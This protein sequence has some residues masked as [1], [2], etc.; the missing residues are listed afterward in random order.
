MKKTIIFLFLGT[1]VSL[2]A[3]PNPNTLVATPGRTAEVEYAPHIIK[4][5]DYWY[6]LKGIWHSLNGVKDEKFVKDSGMLSVKWQFKWENNNPAR[7]LFLRDLKINNNKAFSLEFQSGEADTKVYNPNHLLDASMQSATAVSGSIAKV[8]NR[9]APVE[10][11]LSIRFKRAVPLS[12]IALAYGKGRNKGIGKVRY[13]SGEK[14]LIPV[15]SK[16]ENGVLRTTFRNTGKLSE[17]K[18]VCSSAVPQLIFEDFEAEFRDRLLKYPFVSHLMRP[19]PYGLSA[20]NIHRASANKILQKYK[21]SHMGINFAEWDSQAFFQS[22]NEGNRLF[23]E[24]IAQFGAKPDSREGFFNY[25]SRFWN[26]HKSIFFDKIWGM[27]GAFGTVHYGTEWGGKVAGLELTNH[28]STIPHRTLLRYT[29]GAGR[30][31]NKPW[32]LYLAYYLGKFSPNS[33]RVMPPKDSKGWGEGPDAG[34]SPSFSRRI[35]LSGYFMGA[36]FQSFEAEPWGQAEKKGNTVVLNEN[37][38]VLKEFYDFVSSPAG[39][40]GSWY[41]PILLAVDTHHGMIR[42]GEVWTWSGVKTAQTPGDLMGKHFNRA[43]DYWD[44]NR[45]AWDTPPYSHNMHNSTLGDIFSTELANPPSGKFPRFENYA[46]VI[47]PDEIK[48]TPALRDKLESYVSQGGTLVINSIHQKHLPRAMM[49]AILLPQTVEEDGLVIPKYRPVKTRPALKTAKKNTFAVKQKYGLGNVIMTLPA[50]FTGKDKE[51]PSKYITMLL[52]RLQKEV[53]PFQIKGDCQFII[54]RLAKDH[55]KVAVINNKGVRKNPWERKEQ[56]DNKYT[57]NIT[58]TLPQGAQ[59]SSI[60]RPK[61]LVRGT[62]QVR[63]A[64]PP[65]EVTVLEIK[66]V[67][68]ENPSSLPLIA[69]WKLDGTKGTALTGNLHERQFDMKYAVL[70][71]GKKVYDVSNPLSAVSNRYNPGFDLKS[72]TFTLWA[73]PDFAAKL[74]DRGGYAIAGRYFRVPFYRGEWGF[75]IHDAISLRGPKAQNGRFDHIAITWNASEC[76]FFVN[77]KEYTDNGVPLKTYLNIWDGNFDIG[78]LRRGRR[79][80]GGKISDVR[81]YSR[82]LTPAEIQKLYGESVKEYR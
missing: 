68:L 76:R 70:P 59:V 10:T 33:T 39:K 36:N 63:F 50:Y 42:D 57:S 30:Q 52:E 18:I 40:R 27:S 54:S 58:I 41:T 3:A 53:L 25:M 24:T 20:D 8:Q 65:G 75:N 34:I 14:E 5:R 35:F 44:G 73:A 37:G 7:V 17:M 82:D 69:R 23:K 51:Q 45:A 11:T 66:N 28:T 49:S 26:W 29:A 19:V 6:L 61:K 77:G 55:W 38:K 81:L 79:T 4:G 78:T 64:L 9:F 12:S 56:Y 15:S 1:I 22:L 48:F 21:D 16:D 80:F 32:L 31:Y 74:S 62:K 13:F 2:S 46:V 60:Y 72:G 47:L 67:K 43:I 71:N